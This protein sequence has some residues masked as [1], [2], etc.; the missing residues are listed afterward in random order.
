[1][2]IEIGAYTLCA[3][4][5]ESPEDL[6]RDAADT[7]QIAAGLRATYG[8]AFNRGNRTHTFRF[9][10]TRQYSDVKAAEA[11][12]MDHPAEVPTTGTV[13]FTTEGSS[14]NVRYLYDATV[15][16]FAATQIGVSLRWIYTITGG[17]ISSTAP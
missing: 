16:A 7:L 2:K 10:I 15:H 6:A 14:P 12:L 1:M 17:Q 4:G 3:G 8:K 5:A 9:Q 11:A 13:K